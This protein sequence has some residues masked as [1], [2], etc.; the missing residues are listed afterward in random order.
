[1]AKAKS[2]KP[3][4]RIMI[5]NIGSG[6]TTYTRE[7]VKAGWICVSRDMLR[8]M[9]GDGLYV[10]NP[11]YEPMIEEITQ[12]ALRE[13]LHKGLN[14]ILDECNM[15]KKYRKKVI[16]VAKGFEYQIEAVCTPKLDMKTCVDRRMSK[17]HGE[18]TRETWEMVWKRFDGNYQEPTKDEG[19]DKI[20]NLQ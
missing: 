14:I 19:F 8:Y 20:T 2:P 9:I 16:K 6:K 4:L 1:M 11:E 12:F 3:I 7:L 13:F 18:N 17:N 5:G 15:T 10:F